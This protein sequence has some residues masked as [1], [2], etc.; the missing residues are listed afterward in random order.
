MNTKP[1]VQI[2]D[3]HNYY[4]PTKEI[5]EGCCVG[6]NTKDHPRLGATNVRTS[7]VVNITRNNQGK[8][9]EFETLNTHYAVI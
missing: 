8:I 1:I 6:G 7:R 4:Y 9:T 5:H 3:I 2:S